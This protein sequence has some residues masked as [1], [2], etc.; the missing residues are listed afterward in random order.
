[1]FS[2]KAKRQLSALGRLEAQLET[3]K[4]LTESNKARITREIATLKTRTYST[5]LTA[6]D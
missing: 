5:Q 1:M 2:S 6:K 4:N 3:D